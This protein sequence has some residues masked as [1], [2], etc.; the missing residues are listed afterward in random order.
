MTEAQELA[1]KIAQVPKAELHLHLEGSISPETVSLLGARRGVN[2]TPEAAKAR[3]A[4]TD[5]TGFLDA[6][7]WAVGY[8]KAPEDYSL[9]THRLADELVR[10]NVIYAEVTISAGVMI[11]QGQ[12]VEAN[13]AAIQEVA[14]RY[15]EKGLRLA[16]IFDATR[17]FG[18][19]AAMKVAAL[20]T[21]L[22]PKGVVAFGLGGDEMSVGTVHFRAAYDFARNSG[23]HLVAHA[24]EIGGP[25][26]VREAVDLLG[27]ERIGHGIAVYRDAALADRLATLRIP[28]EVCPTSNVCTGALARQLEVPAAQISEHVLPKLIQKGLT[29][30]LATD[31]PAMFHTD[32]LAEYSH[33][34][35]LGLLEFQIAKMIEAGFSH[36]FLPPEE[37]RPLLE[38]FRTNARAVG[39]L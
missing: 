39:L 35:S 31:D 32:L 23:L 21:Q 19:D 29:V 2:I 12:N 34:I 26:L 1:S 18:A 33:A 8:L 37:K 16:W 24:G 4:Y 30:T 10:Q 6:F 25:E 5:F 13:F 22:Q 36:A 15:R 14:D 3:Y 27:A 17:Q 11:R 20:A 38:K 28:L 9:I 7:K